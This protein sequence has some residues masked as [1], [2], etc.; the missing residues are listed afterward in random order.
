M[1]SIKIQITDEDDGGLNVCFG[2]KGPRGHRDLKK[3]PGV[4][5][6]FSRPFP[7]TN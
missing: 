4:R 5:F 2:H 7:W 3:R 6:F 1:R